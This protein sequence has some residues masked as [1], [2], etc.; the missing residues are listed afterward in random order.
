MKKYLLVALA[1][2]TLTSCGSQPAADSTAAVSSSPGEVAVVSPSPGGRERRRGF[3]PERFK[4]ALDLTDAQMAE[5]KPLFDEQRDGMRKRMEDFHTEMEKT[6]TPEQKK[7][8]A[9]LEKHG[10]ERRT[11]P[12]AKLDLTSEQA[13]KLEDLRQKMR[14]EGRKA[15]EEF[16]AKLV[17]K[18]DPEQKKKFKAMQE[19]M[20][21][22]QEKDND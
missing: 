16:N 6:L 4:K 15:R 5:L 9:E 1:A 19:R 11:P 13:T 20:R 2:A 17:E 7:K 8:L 22:R 21:E 3:D 10:R 12:Y 14:D 18:L